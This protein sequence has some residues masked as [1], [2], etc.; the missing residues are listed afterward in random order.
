LRN[1]PVS[2]F[3]QPIFDHYDR[4]RFELFAYSFHPGGAD[5]VQREIESKVLKFRRMPNMP[6]Q[7]IARIIADDALDILFELG[8]STHLNR[9]EVMAHQPAPVQVSWLGYPHS[10][11][12]SR[13]GH[14]LVDPYLKPPDPRL[15]LERPFEM[16]SSW[17][18]LGSLGFG[19]QE[20][21]AGLPEERAGRLTFGTM[22][23]PYKYAPEAIALWSRVLRAVPGSRFLIVRPEAG[24]TAFREAMARAFERHDIEAGRLASVAVRGTHMRYYN[25]IDIALDTLPQTGGT[26]TCECLWMGVPTVSLVGP[27]LFERLS[28]TNLVNAG[29]A[30]LA[31]ASP[32]AYVAA[33][34]A[35]AADV[36][37][38]R[39]LRRDLRETIRRSPLGDTKG[40]VRDFEA[41]TM[42]T[43]DAGGAA[44]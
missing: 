11:G 24:V 22:N 7:D 12:L 35:L 28:F 4:E 16:P 8:G 40:W 27:A 13:I 34:V 17:V 15:L 41:L 36:T 14:V 9:L 32:D 38:R 39:A 5:N 29:L 6:E 10:S 3:A 19:E 42:R 2:Y 33:A 25:D 20:I 44:L 30:D 43:L 31:V 26:T 37:R 18:T 1:H 23:N 21:A